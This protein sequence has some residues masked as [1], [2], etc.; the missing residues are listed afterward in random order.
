MN[1]RRRTPESEFAA[2][3][4]FTRAIS[5]EGRPGLVDSYYGQARA[6]DTLAAVFGAQRASYDEPGYEFVTAGR[7][8]AVAR[9]ANAYRR[10]AAIARAQARAYAMQLGPVEPAGVRQ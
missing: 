10:Q 4:T 9:S 5:P 7:K 2:V 6:C 8:R 1:R 3:W